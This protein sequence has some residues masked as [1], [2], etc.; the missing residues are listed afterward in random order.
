M[1][2]EAQ[3]HSVIS[4]KKIGKWPATEETVEV[5]EDIIITIIV[6]EDI[7][8]EAVAEVAVVKATHGTQAKIVLHLGV[9]INGVMAGEQVLVL[10]PVVVEV[11]TQDQAMAHVL[12]NVQE[13]ILLVVVQVI[14][15]DQAVEVE[16]IQEVAIMVGHHGILEM[17][18]EAQDLDQ[19]AVAVA[20][21]AHMFVQEDTHQV[22]VHRRVLMDLVVAG[23][24]VV[25]MADHHGIL[26]IVVGAEAQA[27]VLQNV[28]VTILPVVA[29]VIV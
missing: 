2:V 8:G 12:Q 26:T 3:V 22:G 19:E 9:G 11:V 5:R 1:E 25:V 15:L 23:E 21:T 18:M 6:E 4:L 10:D 7:N 28:V 24:A 29:R 14:A 17:E 16:E 27:L 13:I 20:T